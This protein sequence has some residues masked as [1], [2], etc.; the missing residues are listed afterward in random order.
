MKSTT[1]IRLCVVLVASSTYVRAA[2]TSAQA[3]TREALE[4]KLNAL[5]HPESPPETESGMSSNVVTAHIKESVTNVTGTVPPKKLTPPVAPP[6]AR[7]QIPA[8]PVAPKP[9]PPPA[10][11]KA[12]KPPADK[13][14]TNVIRTVAGSVY[15]HAAVLKVVSDGILIS[16]TPD[17]GGMAIIKVTADNLPRDLRQKYGFE[18]AE[19]KSE[20]KH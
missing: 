14:A 13:G 8:E 15:R 4:Q 20:E 11:I 1:L 6:P 9:V 2:D 5:D 12:Y 19:T 10:A 17:Q 18:P 16:Y 3:A 7:S